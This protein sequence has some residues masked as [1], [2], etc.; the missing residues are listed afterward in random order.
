MTP[1]D[2]RIFASFAGFGLMLAG[3]VR[4]TQAPGRRRGLLLLAAGAGLWGVATALEIPLFRLFSLFMTILTGAVLAV[5]ARAPK[6]GY[7]LAAPFGGLSAMSAVGFR[8]L[9]AHRSD[10]WL[11]A[12]TLIAV[13][14]L[15]SLIAG[16]ALAARWRSPP[17][18]TA[19]AA[20]GRAGRE[21]PGP[22]VRLAGP[23][24]SARG[25]F[26]LWT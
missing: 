3:A 25:P 5:E 2:L 23:K 15:S 21:A 20:P 14:G 26:G 9:G 6:R 12:A 19:S 13:G 17:L 16:L 22:H 7:M 18:K 24:L 8:W 11:D 4:L 10:P 1:S